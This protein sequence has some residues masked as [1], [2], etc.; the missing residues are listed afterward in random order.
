MGHE[1]ELWTAAALRR[2]WFRGW[3]FVHDVRFAELNVDHVAVGPERILVIE[4]KWLGPQRDLGRALVEAADQAQ[5]C[6]RKVRNLLR[7]PPPLERVVDPV[8]FVWGPGVRGVDLPPAVNGVRVVVGG[9]SRGWVR[10]QGLERG[11]PDRQAYRAIMAYQR[12]STVPAPKPT[13]GERKR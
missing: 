1:A 11:R 10:M 3:R 7:T 4:T 2:L 13:V 8:V 6:A 9:R 5:R 12:R